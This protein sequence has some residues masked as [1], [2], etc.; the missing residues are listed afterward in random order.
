MNR[1]SPAPAAA[2]LIHLIAISLFGRGSFQF[3][4]HRHARTNVIE[5]PRTRTDPTRLYA[6]MG[7]H[8]QTSIRTRI[9]SR[10]RK[11]ATLTRCQAVNARR[12]ALDQLALVQHQGAVHPRRQIEVVDRRSAPPGLR[13][14]WRRSG[15]RHTARRPGVQIAGRLV[16]QKDARPVGQRARD[17]DAL[18][19]AAGQLRRPVGQPLAQTQHAEQ[20]LGLLLRPR[21]AICPRSSGAAPHSPARRTPGSK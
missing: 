21:H 18:L 2:S 10:K 13:C 20:P 8:V 17:G 5:L 3:S 19:L 15:R 16:G 7:S 11:T 4:S 1:I 6:A 12:D 14:G 9:S